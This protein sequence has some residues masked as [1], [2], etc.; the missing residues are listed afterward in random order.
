M[1]VHSALPLYAV[2]AT[3]AASA[4]A[5]PVRIEFTDY[6]V[7][8]DP[9]AQGMRANSAYAVLTQGTLELVFTG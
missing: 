7:L 3:L 9:S 6:T 8:Y 5:A 2:F 4:L 1:K